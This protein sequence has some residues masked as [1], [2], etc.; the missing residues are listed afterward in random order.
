[1]AVQL[2]PAGSDE[3]DLAGHTIAGPDAAG[4]PIPFDVLPAVEGEPL[5]NT[6]GHILDGDRAIEVAKNTPNHYA[7]PCPRSCT[8]QVLTPAQ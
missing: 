6:V 2:G 1:M 7:Y 5:K 3:I 4:L 8:P